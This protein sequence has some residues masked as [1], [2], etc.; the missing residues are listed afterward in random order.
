M[1]HVLSYASKDLIYIYDNLEFP[2]PINPLN[3]RTQIRKSPS[4]SLVE[5]KRAKDVTK[6]S[7]QRF[8]RPEKTYLHPNTPCIAIPNFCTFSEPET[9]R[10]SRWLADT[11]IY[12]QTHAALPKKIGLSHKQAIEVLMIMILSFTMENRER[13]PERQTHT[14]S[15]IS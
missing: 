11:N 2:F 6:M 4:A 5:C 14:E 3:M 13:E 7:T 12:P 1:K 8:A 10:H 9:Q 15:Q